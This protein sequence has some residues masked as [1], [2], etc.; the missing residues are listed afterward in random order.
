MRLT[1]GY[2]ATPSGDDG[3]ALAVAMARTFGASVDIC[4]VLEDERRVP[5]KGGVESAWEDIVVDRARKWVADAA[6]LFP[7]DTEVTTRVLID[8]SFSGGL[9]SA[10]GDTGADMI[11]VGAAGDGLLGRHSI[12][13]VTNALLHSSSLPVAMA[14]RG[15]RHTTCTGVRSVTFAVGNRPGGADV[16][17]T[18]ITLAEGADLPLRLLSLVALDGSE[19]GEDAHDLSVRQRHVDVLDETTA[20]IRAE[21]GDVA[22]EAVVADGPS[23]EEASRRLEWHDGDVMIVGSSRL[24]RP[25]T[26]FLGST[27]TR[28]LRVVP[29]PVIVVPADGALS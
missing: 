28:M 15:F 20:A 8:D 10:A 6:A 4:L 25:R 21:V 5:A 24:A 22:V 1:V 2:L 29:V 11:V 12:G 26:L 7:P 9:L 17:R 27:A 18:A 13:T 19:A 16:V 14:P 23:I 3:I